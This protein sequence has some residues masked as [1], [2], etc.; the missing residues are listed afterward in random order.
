MKQFGEARVQGGNVRFLYG[1][2][3][4][5]GDI[6]RENRLGGSSLLDCVVYGRLAACTAAKDMLDKN[7]QTLLALEQGPTKLHSL[8]T[9]VGLTTLSLALAHESLSGQTQETVD[10]AT[11]RTQQSESLVD[12]RRQK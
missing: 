5:N 12:L 3:E 9:L 7:T 4:V 8:T 1:A 11:D 6:H 2:G 10:S